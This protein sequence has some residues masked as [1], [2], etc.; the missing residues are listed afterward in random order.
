MM[1]ATFIP[2]KQV[3]EE[4]KKPKVVINKPRFVIK[5]D[6]LDSSHKSGSDNEEADSENITF[7]TKKR[8]KRD[9][10]E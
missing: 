6:D 7:G 1:P 9:D 10:Y 2:E 5:D 4:E 3:E 8:I